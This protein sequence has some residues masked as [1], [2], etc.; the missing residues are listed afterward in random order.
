MTSMLLN[1]I[2]LVFDIVGAVLIWFFVAEINFANKEF[3]LQGDAVIDLED[4]SPEK[5]KAFKRNIMLSRIGIVALVVG[6]IFQL[7]SNLWK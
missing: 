1:S 6:F 7:A 2:G 4:P 5:I 3:Y